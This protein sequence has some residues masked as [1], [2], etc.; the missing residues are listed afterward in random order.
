MTRSE[1]LSTP[2]LSAVRSIE[3]QYPNKKRNPFSAQAHPQHIN[4]YLRRPILNEHEGLYAAAERQWGVVE[5]NHLN[6]YRRHLKTVDDVDEMLSFLRDHEAWPNKRTDRRFVAATFKPVSAVYLLRAAERIADGFTDH[7]FGPSTDYDLLF[8]GSRL[9]PKAVFGLAASEA[10]G[11]P[12]R[13]ENFSAG[14]SMPC[15]RILRDAGYRIVTK[16]EGDR[17][18]PIF[19]TDEEKAWSEGRSE[20]VS[21]LRKER[22]SGLSSAKR[23]QFRAIHGRLYCERC[24]MDPIEAFGSEVG[25]ACIEVHHETTH[26]REMEEGHLT[27]LEDLQCLCANCHRVRHRELKLAALGA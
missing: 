2:R 24:Q 22:A 9:P 20:L 18:E 6:E 26:V 15:F 11:F 4:F 8:N 12:V 19:L 13:P 5:P 16:G 23:D 7:G 21:H 17:S 27:R 10:L 1:A 25:E 3:L 14:E